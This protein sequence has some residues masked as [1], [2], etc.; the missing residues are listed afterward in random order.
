MGQI[1]GGST[2]AYKKILGS[3]KK[4]NSVVLLWAEFERAE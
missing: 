1:L 4:F 2:F 3:K